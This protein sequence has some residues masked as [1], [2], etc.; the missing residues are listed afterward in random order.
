VRDTAEPDPTEE[1]WRA[2][3]PIRQ[4][5]SNPSAFDCD[6]VAHRELRRLLEGL[7]AHGV[8]E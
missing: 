6:T 4:Q 3:F 5:L 8:T 7:L 1:Q 2:S